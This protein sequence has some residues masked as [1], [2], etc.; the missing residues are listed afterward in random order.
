MR[1][2]V[3]GTGRM[4]A[5]V[6]AELERRGHEVLAWVGREAG[7]DAAVLS[8]ER[9]AGAD[10]AVEFTVPGAAP[11]VVERLLHAGIPVV[12]G[13]T[14]W[15]AALPRMQ[16]LARAQGGALLHAANFSLGLHVMLRAVRE[17]ARAFAAHPEFRPSLVEVHHVH[18]KD[19]PSGTARVIAAAAREAGG[20]EVPIESVRAGEAVGTHTLAFATPHEAVSLEHD[21][22]DRA[23][24][25]VGAVT[26]AEWLVGRRG[27]FTLDDVLSGGSA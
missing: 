17:L 20:I 9:L 6:R 23:V 14:G 22:R 19:A 11:L 21:V 24:F 3:V 10:V 13:T 7:V 15:D 8:R 5:L 4:G 2:V 16:D 25:A 27:V 26:A 12:S 1:A 18:K